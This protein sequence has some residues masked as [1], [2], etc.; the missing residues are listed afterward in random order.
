MQSQHHLIVVGICM[1]QR[2]DSTKTIFVFSYKL[3]TKR[4]TGVALFIFLLVEVIN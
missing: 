3:P 1:N 4:A 2:R